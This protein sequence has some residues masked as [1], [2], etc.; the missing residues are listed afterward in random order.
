MFNIDSQTENA[1]PVIKQCILNVVKSK[2]ERAIKDFE[3]H[4]CNPTMIHNGLIGGVVEK[5][6]KALRKYNNWANG[7]NT[8][9]TGV[10]FKKETGK[11]IKTRFRETS[12][13]EIAGHH[14]NLLR[15]GGNPLQ[16]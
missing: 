9:T 5:F 12:S 15:G 10:L 1:D 7:L 14:N 6:Q 13:H 3:T 4:V 11:I 8:G 2:T 16:P